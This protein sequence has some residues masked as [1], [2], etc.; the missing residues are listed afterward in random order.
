MYGNSTVPSSLVVS[1]LDEL[2]LQISSIDVLERF[3]SELEDS[4][5]EVSMQSK[6]EEEAPSLEEFKEVF[7]EISFEDVF[8]LTLQLNRRVEVIASKSNFPFFIVIPRN[9]HQE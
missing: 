7:E 8:S 3:P 6:L 2:S 5:L 4:S 9:H 1:L